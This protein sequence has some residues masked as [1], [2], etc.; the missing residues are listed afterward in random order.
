MRQRFGKQ[1]AD[2]RLRDAGS[3]IS[4][5][6]DGLGSLYTDEGKLRVWE[7]AREGLLEGAMQAR[8]VMATTTSTRNRKKTEEPLLF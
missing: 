8:A 2:A 7:V 4:D 1:H 3:D 5:L 6:C